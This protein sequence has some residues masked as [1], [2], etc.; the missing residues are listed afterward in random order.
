MASLQHQLTR[1][2]R[3]TR[4]PRSFADETFAKGS[5]VVGCDHFDHD[6]DS[7]DISGRQG[8][9]SIEWRW[10]Q[11]SAA[12]EGIEVDDRPDTHAKDLEGFVV[13]DGE[14]EAEYSDEEEE[15][16]AEY[17]DEEDDETEAYCS[18]DEEEDNYEPLVRTHAIRPHLQQSGFASMLQRWRW[19]LLWAVRRRR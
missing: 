17:S 16:E 5:G 14:E 1:S 11:D 18:D 2:G 13:S 4:A 10:N 3:A 7:G 19:R 9:K 12:F 8:F 6:Y 15:E